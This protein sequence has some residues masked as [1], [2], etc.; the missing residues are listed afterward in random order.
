MAAAAVQRNKNENFN[1]WL[2]EKLVRLNKDIDLDVFV[3]YIEGILEDDIDD[4]EKLESLA[5]LL[6]DIL[7]GE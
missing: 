2:S 3:S 1:T 6:G 7:V 5:G 4:E